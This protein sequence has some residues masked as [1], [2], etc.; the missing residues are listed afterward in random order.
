MIWL[1][2]VDIGGQTYRFATEACEVTDADGNTYAYAE[3]LA[4]PS[5]AYGATYGAG[6]VSVGI[7][8]ESDEDWPRVVADGHTLYRRSAVLR[9]WTPGT[10]LERARVVLRGLTASPTWG[11][12]GEPLSVSIIRSPASQTAMAPDSQAA[13]N[14]TTWPESA[15]TAQGLSYTIIIGCPGGTED[16]TPVP[17]V[18]VPQVVW[19]GFSPT[20]HTETFSSIPGPMTFTLALLPIPSS[21]SVTVNGVAADYFLVGQYSVSIQIPVLVAGDDVEI[22]YQE[23]ST[24]DVES[25][26]AW[27][28]GDASAVRLGVTRSTDDVWLEGDETANSTA[29]GLGRPMEAVIQGWPLLVGGMGTAED[30]YWVGFRDDSIYGGGIRTR[31]GDLMRGAG[32]VI[33]WVLTTYYAGPVDLG[34]VQAVR[35]YLNR[36]KVDTYI[37]QPVNMVDWLRREILPLLPVELREGEQGIFAA[38]VRWDLTEADCVDHLDASLGVVSRVGEVSY[39]DGDIKNQ[40]TIRYRPGRESGEWLASRTVTARAGWLT[41]YS[42][43]GLSIPVATSGDPSI[44]PLPEC[45]ASQ[46]AYGVQAVTL[47]A[48]AVWDSTTAVLV[49]SH[50]AARYALPR[51]V[52]RYQGDVEHLEIGQGIVLTDPDLHLDAVVCVVTDVVPAVTEGD[53]QVDLIVL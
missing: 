33:E 30:E 22:T 39:T 25:W 9:R 41:T 32:D 38:A 4:E 15:E 17:V 26:V 7:R 43:G 51:M 19:G 35:D 14:S 21:V 45:A 12:A 37:N 18:P 8:I 47:D 24:G 49:A 44:V 42:T 16:P 46:A 29:D 6:E 48:Y 3:G 5:V 11:A 23:W 10:V 36:F 52:V 1:Y 40:I 53:A 20:S 31:R 13:V 34:R 50:I 2:E 28:G 27:I